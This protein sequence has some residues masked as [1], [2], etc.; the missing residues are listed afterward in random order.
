MKVYISGR[1]TGLPIDVVREKFGDAEELLQDI[2]FIPVNPLENG[3]DHT[4]TWSQHM[5]RDIE[6]LMSCDI[7]LMLDNW[8]DSKGA[9]I[10]YNIA[11][12]MGKKILFEASLVGDSEI[13]VSKIQC[14]VFEATGLKIKDY[15]SKSRRREAFYARMLFIHHAKRLGINMNTISQLTS[16]D[17]STVI[18]HL[19]K[20]HTDYRYDNT[21]RVLAERVS[22]I[23]NNQK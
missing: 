23:I 10:E 19:K 13:H 3:L 21:F 17:R 18:Y 22:E 11:Q 7:I 12:E 8:R 5:V 15:S 1:I 16:R 2:G 9:R 6:M 20:Y 4:H 14:A